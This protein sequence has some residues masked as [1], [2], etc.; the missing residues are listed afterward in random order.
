M[1][2]LRFIVFVL[3]LQLSTI[4]GSAVA[5]IPAKR[6][7]SVSSS[8]SSSSSSPS[9]LVPQRILAGGAGRCLGQLLLYPVDALRTLA[10]TRDTKTL[11]DLGTRVLVSG[12]ATTSSFALLAGAI[13]FSIFGAPARRSPVLAAPLVHPPCRELDPVS[14]PFP[15]CRHYWQY[16]QPHTCRWSPFPI[17]LILFT[18][19]PAQPVPQIPVPPPTL[20]STQFQHMPPHRARVSGYTHGSPFSPYPFASARASLYNFHLPIFL[21]SI[22]HVALVLSCSVLPSDGCDFAILPAFASFIPKERGFLHPGTVH[23]TVSERW[24]VGC[25]GFGHDGGVGD[26]DLDRS[27]GMGACLRMC[28]DDV[29]GFAILLGVFI[30]VLYVIAHWAC[31]RSS[32]N[33][34]S[35]QFT[36][37]VILVLF[38]ILVVWVIDGLLWLCDSRF[39]E[40]RVVSMKVTYDWARDRSMLDAYRTVT[41]GCGRL[42]RACGW[43]HKTCAV[44]MGGCCSS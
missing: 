28:F 42:D 27:D 15:Y 43:I 19:A 8:L 37:D 39:S 30:Y 1:R 38:L 9:L 4:G 13:Q 20:V 22:P 5:M 23:L 16:Y 35:I 10:Q 21:R 14:C 31:T 24:G 6:Q 41:A 36:L 18:P 3:L 2:S 11:A 17:C 26:G 34:G 12:C 25:L 7:V 33:A 29:E 32:T 40:G 44:M